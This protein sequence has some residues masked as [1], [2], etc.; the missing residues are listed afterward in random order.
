LKKR[1]SSSLRTSR[2]KTRQERPN[3]NLN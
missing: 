2:P 3:K 1:L